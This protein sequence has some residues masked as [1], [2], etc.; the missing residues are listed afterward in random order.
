MGWYTEH[1]VDTGRAPALF[2]LVGFVVTFVVVRSITRR[3][4]SRRESEAP[5]APGTAPA[6]A[7]ATRPRRA[8]LGDVSV[9]GIHVHHQVWGILLV[10]L[11]GML[12]FRYSPGH[13]WSEVLALL[14]G[15][16]AALALDEFALWLYV[17]DVYWTE[18]GQR[19][20]DAILVGGALGG[21]L[22]LS[23][24]PI[25]VTSDGAQGGWVAYT[26]TVVVHLALAFVC[27]LKGKLV[28][29]L[30]GVV[31]PVVAFVGAVRLAKP[32]SFWARRR[33]ARRPHRLARAQ[34]RFGARYQARRERVR[35]LVGGRADGD[36]PRP[37]A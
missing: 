15:A 19:S 32:S 21:A 24:S 29:G 2:A 11:T 25:G 8:L 20:I 10:L 7:T 17:D 34:A 33:Y 28:T 4:R 9:G 27:V 5:P 13:P 22:L 16:G 35:T 14:F 3:I 12:E 1:V 26:V 23:A 18:E 6:P 30:L 31:V 37:A 36:P